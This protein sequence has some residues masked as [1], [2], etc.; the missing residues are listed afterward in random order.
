MAAPVLPTFTDLLRQDPHWQDADPDYAA[1]QGVVG[2]A[3]AATG[4]G[5]AIV[6]H[7]MATRTPV[8]VAFV[9]E[10]DEDYVQVAHSPMIYPA[11]P[12]NAVASLDA[13]V[14]VITGRNPDDATPI[15]LPNDAFGRINDT[16]C[17][18]M[19]TIVGATGHAAGPPV[20]RSGPHAATVATATAIRGRRALLLP[21]SAASHAVGFL[22]DGRYS[23]AAFYAQFV[24]G[25]FDSADPDTVALW[26]ETALWFRMASTNNGAGHSVLRVAA[27]VQP[28]VRAQRLLTTFTNNHVKT[29][30]ATIGVGGPQLSNNAF[31]VG[32]QDLR[33][34]LTDNHTNGQVFERS[35]RTKTFRDKHG[36]SLEQRVL[37]FTCAVDEAHMTP[38]HGLLV[39]APRGRE[40]SILNC[41][42]AERAVNSSLAV[43][44]NN[45]PT[46]TPTLLDTVFR[47]Y[48]PMNN[49]LTLGHGLTPFA[50]VCE[51]H[52]EVEHLKRVVKSAELVEGGHT[53][54]LSDAQ[55]LTTNDI[56]LPTEPFIAVEK[57]MG[58]SIVVD[59][60][61][62]PGTDIAIRIK[63]V[64]ARICPMLHRIVSQS[65]PSET[66]GMEYVWRVMF[67]LQQDYFA[68]LKHMAAGTTPLVVPS[69]SRIIDQVESF[70]ASSLCELPS[71]WY[72]RA[73]GSTVPRSERQQGLTPR[74][75]TGTTPRVNPSPDAGLMTRFKDC[76]HSS[77]KSMIGDH[78]VAVPKLGGKEICLSWALRGSC[79]NNCKRKDQH[80]QY[81]RDVVQK[82]HALM[83]TC[84]VA[85]PSG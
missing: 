56:C 72:T 71:T 73:Q 23:L 59:V 75:Q 69:F 18:D 67:E 65:A 44:T 25:K 82:I 81:S 22:P 51:G 85:S 79:S 42:F 31:Q 16:R 50:I 7:N 8:A 1:L 3:S 33:Q 5:T 80:K 40:Y 35:L 41:A 70:R 76:G 68:F 12:T 77:I 52:S 47:S 6:Y 13:L 30:M 9:V 15:V 39:N 34:T 83:D 19:A 58:W 32:I 28:N 55:A 43:T 78:Q 84:G 66:V 64:V 21:P 45:C 29:L 2:H 24:Q 20:Y 49:G 4:A 38:I 26:A 48:Q 61:H 11:D 17:Q 53:L 10:G 62:G 27:A 54:S 63:D 74:E 14:V 57:L 46:V 36:A 60:F 37:R